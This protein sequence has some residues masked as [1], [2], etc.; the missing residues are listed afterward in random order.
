MFA[1][2]NLALSCL[3]AKMSEPWLFLE[4]KDFVGVFTHLLRQEIYKERQAR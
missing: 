1:P 4:R 3:R 2:Y